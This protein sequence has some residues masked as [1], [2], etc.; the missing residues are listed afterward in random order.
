M[1]RAA[2]HDRLRAQRIIRMENNHYEEGEKIFKRLM[3]S[4]GRRD[5]AELDALPL[6]KAVKVAEMASKLQRV[7]LGLPV[8]GATER[9]PQRIPTVD[10]SFRKISEHNKPTERQTDFASSELFQDDD[11]LEAAQELILTISTGRDRDRDRK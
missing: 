5:E 11:A 8:Q 4:V 10:V 9:E 7:A 2:H 6:D 1:Y 3:K